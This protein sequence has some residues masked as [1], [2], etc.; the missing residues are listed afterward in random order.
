MNLHIYVCIG[1]MHRKDSRMLCIYKSRDQQKTFC[2]E[3]GKWPHWNKEHA[4]NILG[5]QDKAGKEGFTDKTV[6]DRKASM[7]EDLW[8]VDVTLGTQVTTTNQPSSYLLPAGFV[9]LWIV[10]C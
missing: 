9:L 1:T 5:I 2:Y 7:F 8:E 3:V 4:S 6:W 10:Q